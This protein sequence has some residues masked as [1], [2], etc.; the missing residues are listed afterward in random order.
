LREASF[1]QKLL[2]IDENI[3]STH[4]LMSG[5]CLR[6]SYAASPIIV[7]FTLIFS[8]IFLSLSNIFLNTGESPVHRA[9]LRWG[10][11]LAFLCSSLLALSLYALQNSNQPRTPRFISFSLYSLQLNMFSIS[12]CDKATSLVKLIYIYH[13]YQI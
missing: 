8:R 2:F 11:F 1:S 4:H 7:I 6:A 10:K 3:E 13:F 9:V 12:L 5:L